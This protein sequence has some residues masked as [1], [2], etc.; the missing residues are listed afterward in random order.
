MLLKRKK[1]Q[2]H[3]GYHNSA[4]PLSLNSITN[5]WCLGLIWLDA[6]SL[7]NGNKWWMTKRMLTKTRT[8]GSPQTYKNQCIFD[9]D[10]DLWNT[11][12][13][14]MMAIWLENDHA[15][16]EVNTGYIETPTKRLPHTNTRPNT[17]SLT[18]KLHYSCAFGG[19]WKVDYIVV[20]NCEKE[21]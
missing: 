7:Y 6:A 18:G 11:N 20:K 12:N 10:R 5:Y 4:Y 8:V 13:V 9:S 1:L 19:Q 16:L 21:K 14:K 2:E 3:T 17:Y 15:R